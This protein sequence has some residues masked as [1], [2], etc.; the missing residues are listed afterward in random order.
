VS[1]LAV[2]QFAARESSEDFL[3]QLACRFRAQF[4]R[5]A[6]ASTFRLVDEIDAERMIKR[7][8]EGMIVIDIVSASMLS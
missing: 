2:L 5:H 6:L 8:M 7:R 1:S 4:H 3:D